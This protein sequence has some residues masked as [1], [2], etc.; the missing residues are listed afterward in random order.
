MTRNG[1]TCGA[2]RFR[3]AAVLA[4]CG[5]FPFL[6]GCPPNTPEPPYPGAENGMRLVAASGASFLQGAEDSLASTDEKPAFSSG[7]SYNYWMDT[8]EVTQQEYASVTGRHPVPDT[9]VSGKGP[10]YPVCYVSWY[11]A[12]LFCNQKSK[13]DSLDTVYSYM[14]LSRLPNGSVYECAGLAVDYS[15]N[16]YRLPTEA[17]WE[18]AARQASSRIFIT[19][20]SDGL[21][22]SDIAWY[23]ANS[24][25]STHSVAQK[26]PN[27]LGLYDMAGNLF[28]W[29]GDW[30]G[31][32][33]KHA[34]TN[35]IGAREPNA[36]Y[37]RVIKGGS[38]RDGLYT[39]RPT[40]R[41]ATYTV[42]LSSAVDYI[43][44]RCARGAIPAPS[45][46]T[47]DT[48]ALITNSVRLLVSDP[49]ALFG[50]TAARLVFVNVTASARTLCYV[51][52]GSPHPYV[53]EFLDRA[54]VNVPAL[55]P[56]GRFAAYCTRGNS[57]SGAANIYIRSLDSLAAAPVRLASDSA[58]EPR[59]WADRATGDTF[60]IYT[61]S[62]M[63]NADPQWPLTKTMMVKMANGSPTNTIGELVSDGSFHDGLS[64]TSQYIVTGYTKLIMRDRFNK[65]DHLLFTYPNNGK[66]PAGS[67]QACNVSIAPDTVLGGGRCLFLD[68]GTGQE[69]SSITGTRYG[70]HEYLFMAEFNGRVLSCYKCP[71]GEA[72]WDHTEWSNI[73][74]FAVSGARNAAEAMRGVW[75]IDLMSSSYR[76]IAEGTELACPAL[77]IASSSLPNADSLALDSLGQYMNPHVH[78]NQ[79]Y[80]TNRMLP[81]WRKHRQ[82]EVVFFGSSHFA[83]G[84]D[85]RWFTVKTA[86]NMGMAGGDLAG[87]LALV[88]NYALNHCPSLKCVSIDIMIGWLNRQG[89]SQTFSYGVALSK[90]Y[91]YDRNHGFWA[92]G[93]PRNFENLVG[94]A[95]CPVFA[96]IDELG[97]ERMP[98]RG[99]G[100]SSPI[101]ED[102]LDWRAD[103]PNVVANL[104]SLRALA[105]LLA[106]KNIH[107]VIVVMPESPFYRTTAAY[108]RYGPTRAEGEKIIARLDSL[109]RNNPYCHFYDANLGGNHDYGEADA[110]DWDHLSEAG[111]KKMSQR[112]DSLVHALL[113]Y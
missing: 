15:R 83:M 111:A 27:S 104:D 37:E 38:Y 29:T 55:S 21:F 69:T 35:S 41:G 44:F 25:G 100:G 28:E 82:M 84:I 59:W 32:Y 56:D 90:G 51:D 57:A 7:F 45:Y 22:A 20:A 2:A 66:G 96:N 24:G 42:G 40:H 23:S 11:D 63:D 17:E 102:A 105:A 50:A 49:M 71:D 79:L 8:T 86:Y 98:S 91:N 47:A 81:F 39:L 76:K 4:L 106:G 107:L 85:P 48:G 46:I 53:H 110:N 74:R 62:G 61:T 65:V 30:K 70:V 54:D 9:G 52:F 99:W 75:A 97:L 3:A 88:R 112:L 101:I 19:A 67:S 60:L 43:G 10:S 5:A 95:P 80:F 58:F 31:F 13:Q 89:G 103:D 68:F 26:Q 34:M 108:T 78:D 14:S 16:G 73:G 87:C 6:A 18:Y 109:T 64:A 77:W 12:I 33:Q 94:L 93:L 1:P 72:S 92:G 113:N 36:S